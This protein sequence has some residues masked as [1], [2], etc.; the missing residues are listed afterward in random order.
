M[1]YIAQQDFPF[2]PDG[3]SSKTAVKGE[4]VLGL[5]DHLIPGL[6]A[7]G[8]IASAGSDIAKSLG[9]AP[10]NKDASGSVK[11]KSDGDNETV[12]EELQQLRNEYAEFAG[13]KFYHGWGVEDLRAKIA[14]LKA[15]AS[16]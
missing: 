14:E 10:E 15:G 6:E 16:S 3:V 4:P 9:S 12:D 13:K 5:P 8:F 2:S 1:T 7:A 11:S